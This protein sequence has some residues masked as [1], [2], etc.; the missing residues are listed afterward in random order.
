MA[1]VGDT[2][3]HC[4]GTGTQADPYIYTT[5]VGFKEAIEV[6][7]SYV[8]AGEEN[9]SFDANNGVITQV[10][11]RCKYIDGKGTTVRN[12]FTQNSSTALVRTYTDS[13]GYTMD[14]RNMNFYNMYIITTSVWQ[15][16]RFYYDEG[17]SYSGHTK[18]FTNCNFTGVYKGLPHASSNGIFHA[19]PSNASAFKNCT[20]N[21]NFDTCSNVDFLYIFKANQDT[22]PI[23]FSNC[24]FCI[25]GKTLS[26]TNYPVELFYKAVMD[27]CVV[28]NSSTNPLN[29]ASGI[30]SYVDMNL[31][32]SGTKF[33]T[34]YNYVKLYMNHGTYTESR[35]AVNN[36]HVLVNKTRLGVETFQGGIQMQET[37]TTADDYIYDSDKLAAK[38]FM[39]GRVIE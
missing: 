29:I 25:S 19:N 8:E 11:F 1:N 27:S 36:S 4:T 14:I 24:T 35:F 33:S 20:F 26:A 32:N 22:Y 15:M 3:P 12:L 31:I 23:E 10:T 18:L 5:E 13:D 9:L 21:F 7:K 28:M 17:S 37:D 16:A 6:I 38:G 34:T 2:L 39:V 30:R